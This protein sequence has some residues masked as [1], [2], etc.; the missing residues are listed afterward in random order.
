[1]DQPIALTPLLCLNCNTA[2]PAQPDERA[3]VCS[4]CGQGM[5]LDQQKGLIPLQV[6]YSAGIVALTSG[7][8]YWVVE[9]QVVLQRETY[10]SNSQSAREAEQFWRQPRRFFIPAYD[11]PLDVML[12]QAVKLLVQQPALQAGPATRFEP[13]TL[14]VE[15]IQPAAEFVVMAVEAARKDMLKNVDFQVKLG[16]PALWILP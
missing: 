1:M 14:A 7:M 10:R 15:D 16:L 8:P 5:A 13:V 11:A 12:S 4:Q 3:W 6:F 9:G 2:I